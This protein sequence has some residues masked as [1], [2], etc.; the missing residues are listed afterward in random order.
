MSPMKLVELIVF[1]VMPVS[2]LLSLLLLKRLT[3]RW[4]LALALTFFI[5]RIAIIPIADFLLS[6]TG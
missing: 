2:T 6:G 3:K 1:V 5:A 4:W